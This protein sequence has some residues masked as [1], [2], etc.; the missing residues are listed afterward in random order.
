MDMNDI[1]SIVTLLSFCFFVAFAIW[2]WRPARR[3]DLDEAAQLPFLG[4][5]DH[6]N[7]DPR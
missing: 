7:G 6:S 3:A 4:D 5:D 1:R 2:A